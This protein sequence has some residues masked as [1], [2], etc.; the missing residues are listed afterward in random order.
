MLCGAAIK[1]FVGIF[2]GA[3][4]PNRDPAVFRGTR[5]CPYLPL[6]DI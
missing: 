6:A 2:P 3:R 4:A 5:R 1:T